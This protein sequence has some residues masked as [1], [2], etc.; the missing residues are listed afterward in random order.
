MKNSAINHS[1]DRLF[2]APASQSIPSATSTSSLSLAPPN[3]CT[4]W[5]C[6]GFRECELCVSDPG[7]LRWYSQNLV[8][9]SH[10]LY[11][12]RIASHNLGKTSSAHLTPLL[13]ICRALPSH[14]VHFV[15]A[16]P[17][18]LGSTDPQARATPRAQTKDPILAAHLFSSPRVG[19]LPVCTWDS[20]T[21]FPLSLHC[22]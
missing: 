7:G 13:I 8:L 15:I 20:T 1:I 14:P 18:M 16:T 21:L 22:D 9:C 4:A 10:E 19:S 3:T 11:R 6:L 2:K 5:R 17:A 12:G